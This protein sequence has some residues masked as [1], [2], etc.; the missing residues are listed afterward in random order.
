MDRDI[1]VLYGGVQNGQEYFSIEACKLINNKTDIETTT[2]T[3]RCPK[4]LVKNFDQKFPINRT[5]SLIHLMEAAIDDPTAIKFPYEENKT[6][7]IRLLKVESTLMKV[8]QSI[9]VATG[10][11]ALMAFTDFATKCGSDRYLEKNLDLVIAKLQTTEFLNSSITE[12]AIEYL[13]AIQQRREIEVANRAY[14]MSI[15]GT[16]SVSVTKLA[17]S[18]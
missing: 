2:I 13:E 10:R 8:M 17:S 5:T 9:M 16:D 7:R 4:T 15:K 18:K 14:R 3:F 11:N 12:T 6:E 1:S